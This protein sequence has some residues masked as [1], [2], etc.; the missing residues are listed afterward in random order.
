[1]DRPLPG[2]TA[3]ISRWRSIKGEIDRRWSIEEEQGKRKEKK[4]KRR[5]KKKKK[6]RNTSPARPRC[7]WVALELSLPSPSAGDF[8]PRVGRE[9]EA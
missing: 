5:K 1:M 9:I 6:R 4:R 3:K 2:G 8:S 7:P